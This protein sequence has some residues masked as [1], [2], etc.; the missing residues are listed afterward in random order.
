[1][2]S[3]NP[4]EEKKPYNSNNNEGE[5]YREACEPSGSSNYMYEKCIQNKNVKHTK[6]LK[7]KR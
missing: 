7:R 3:I 6:W 5:N 2:L 1:M 4:P